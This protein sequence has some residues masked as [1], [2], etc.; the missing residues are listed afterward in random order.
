ME[1]LETQQPLPSVR[2]GWADWAEVEA[3][4]A[5]VERLGRGELTAEEFRGFRLRHGVYGQRQP[6]RYMV[7]VKVP[8]G[9]LTANQFEALGRLAEHF[10]D[11]Q[12]QVTTRQ[13]LQLHY[14]RLEEVPRIMELLATVGLTTREA[15]GNS[16]RNVTACPLAGLCRR[17]EFDVFPCAAST[18]P[19][20]LRNPR[21]QRLPRKF[22]IAF[23]GCAEDCAL[24]AINDI[25]VIARTERTNGHTERG[26]RL[27]AGGG[28]GHWPQAAQ[29]LA[30]FVPANELPAWIEAIVEVFNQYGNRRDRNRA[31]LKFVIAEKGFDWFRD[32]VYA[33]VRERAPAAPGG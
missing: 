30:E 19:A 3:F 5:E 25:G 8:A 13:D 20:L 21:T 22:K 17:E 15:C 16:V 12:A 4:R 26:F 11:G 7:R 23:S 2:A 33:R 18:A 1:R 24:A 29:A 32:Q 6:E 27:L 28:L 14:V 10:A 31:R 9:R